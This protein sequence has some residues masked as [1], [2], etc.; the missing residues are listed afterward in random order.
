MGVKRLAEFIRSVIPADV[1]QLLFLGGLVCLIA[2]HGLRWWPEGLGY[3]SETRRDELGG[4][5]YA[6]GFL[7]IYPFIFSA[8]AAYYVSFWPASTR[9][10]E[11]FGWSVSLFFCD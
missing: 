1:F 9:C 11:S 10:G 6:V 4:L 8:M 7:F 3:G 2:A 5:L